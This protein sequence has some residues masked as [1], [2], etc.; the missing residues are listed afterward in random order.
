MGITI[1]LVG[2]SLST[3]D[4]VALVDTSLTFSATN[5]SGVVSGCSALNDQG[6]AAILRNL[7][8]ADEAGTTGVVTVVLRAAKTYSVCVRYSPSRTWIS[9]VD[10]PNANRF[11]VSAATIARASL[12]SGESAIDVLINKE[13][14]LEV[15]GQGLLVD[16]AAVSLRWMQGSASCSNGTLV[17][18]GNARG[19]ASANNAGTAG[20]VSA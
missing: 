8:T 11:I 6:Q 15:F 12:L 17:P 5:S 14:Q 18:G 20:T 9:A 16:A 19:L 2:T 1:T 13:F 10:E 4:Q 3:A 7:Y